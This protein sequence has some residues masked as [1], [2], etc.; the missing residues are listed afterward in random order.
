M[1]SVADSLIWEPV[2]NWYPLP[3]QRTQ[4]PPTSVSL[5]LNLGV[6]VKM[7][8]GEPRCETIPSSPSDPNLRV[9]HCY[10]LVYF[11]PS[12]ASV[13]AHGLPLVEVNGGY[14]LGVWASR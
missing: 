8:L 12:W 5:K 13:A 9:R 14:S 7:V 4:D 1:P 2:Q 3:H 6:T 10:L 11:W